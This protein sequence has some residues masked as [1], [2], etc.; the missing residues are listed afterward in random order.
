MGERMILAGGDCFCPIKS[1]RM[2]A[3]QRKNFLRFGVF[4][5]IWPFPNDL[6]VAS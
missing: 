4:S 2:R 5:D 6:K 3:N 1:D